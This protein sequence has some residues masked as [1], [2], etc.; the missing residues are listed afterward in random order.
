[1]R[2][3]PLLAYLVLSS[4]AFAAAPS[5][6]TLLD[7]AKTKFAPRQ[8]TH[9]EAKVFMSTE[10]GEPASALTGD[11]KQDDPANAA[12]WPDARVVH[13]EC[14]AWL[15]T[16]R[17]AS[18]RVTFRGIQIYG[19]RIDGKLDLEFRFR[20]GL[21]NAHSPTKSFCGTLIF[22]RFTSS[23]RTLRA[24]MQTERRSTVISF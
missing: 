4:M 9:A 16:D 11:D 6:P 19:M 12:N 8:L 22:R 2:V 17:E 15:C 1:M 10:L 5:R 21:G 20:F 23:S 14:L 13:A 24:S 7:L 3:V 18:S